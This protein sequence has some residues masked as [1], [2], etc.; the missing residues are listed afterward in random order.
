MG[1]IVSKIYTDL[2]VL[3][4][5]SHIPV[6]AQDTACKGDGSGQGCEVS[7]HLEARHDE[8]CHYE[9]Q[10]G[11]TSVCCVAAQALCSISKTCTETQVLVWIPGAWWLLVV[12]EWRQQL[13][14]VD[15][16]LTKFVLILGPRPVG[17]EWM[18]LQ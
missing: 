17:F 1:S 2:L 8:Q 5:I 12:R 6:I 16:S 13:C 4:W 11:M 3:G 15:R 14:R 10:L 18:G 7:V 9:Q